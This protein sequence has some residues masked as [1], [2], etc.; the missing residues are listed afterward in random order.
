MSQ[1]ITQKQLYNKLES[2]SNTFPAPKGESWGLS[3]WSPGDRYGT[4]YQL[5]TRDNETGGEHTVG[6][7]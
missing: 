6:R 4:R 2:F 7:P 1:R 5:V 3:I